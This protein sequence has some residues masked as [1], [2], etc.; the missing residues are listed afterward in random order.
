[1]SRSRGTDTPERE[2][3]PVLDRGDAR[4]VAR[5]RGAWAPEPLTPA[6]RTAFD[7]RLQER[8]ESRARGRGLWPA[9]GAGLVAASLG[10]LVLTN[11][12]PTVAPA[13]E[14][15]AITGVRADADRTARAA[16]MLYTG[17]EEAYEGE[18][19]DDTLPAEYAAIAGVFLDY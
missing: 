10:W 15:V 9:L 7:A 6:R 8:I 19:S 4:L 17:L 2:E 1:M 13:P 5:M 14:R 3:R 11:Q 18:V 16:A 12:D